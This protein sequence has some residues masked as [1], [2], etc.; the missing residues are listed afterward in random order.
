MPLLDVLL[1]RTP[2]A[3]D[4]ASALAACLD[5]PLWV[6]SVLDGA[7]YADVEALLEQA[8]AAAR[9]L[10]PEAVLAALQTHPRIGE[11]PTGDSAHE[12]MSR[13]E[14]S[15]VARDAE[16][17]ERLAAGNAAYEAR[18]GHVFL[19]RAAGLSQEEV[20]TAL[21]ARLGNDAATELEVAGDQLRQ[22]ALLRLQAALAA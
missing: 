15:G 1:G 7:P 3:G 4:E 13:L 11:R 12:R 19:V 16:T 5:S 10:P 21:D 22:I 20:L 18:F 2:P 8:D 14:Q 9:A 17:T 6:A